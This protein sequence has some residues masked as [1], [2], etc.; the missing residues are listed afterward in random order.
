MKSGPESESE[1]CGCCCWNEDSSSSSL[2]YSDDELCGLLIFALDGGIVEVLFSFSVVL[3][4][5]GAR[6][7][8]CGF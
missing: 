7:D 1:S 8:G 3:K 6:L 4:F 5:L 2:V